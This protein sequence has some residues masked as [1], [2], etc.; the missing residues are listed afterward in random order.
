[1]DAECNDPRCPLN[2]RGVPHRPHDAIERDAVVD[3]CNDPQCPLTR[4]G[5]PHN[6][7]G[8]MDGPAA[9][10]GDPGGPEGR[11]ADPGGGPGRR[12]GG[13]GGSAAAAGGGAAAGDAGGGAGGPGG[14]DAAAGASGSDA[15]SEAGGPHATGS[16]TS[17]KGI[18]DE[19]ARHLRE[20]GA[21]TGSGPA[22]AHN[23]PSCAP[24]DAERIL[25]ASEPHDI[26]GVPPG[27]ALSHVRSR[28]KWLVKRHDAARGIIH[29]S[30][31]ERER[32]SMIMA[33]I[34][35]A[36]EAIKSARGASG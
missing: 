7:H 34:N 10:L 1:M 16:A 12:P 27:A 28:Y 24:E 31:P 2:R 26:L 6:S 36:F 8:P 29:K 23:G 3:P 17:S 5:M 30:A 11:G 22:A 9:G 18:L 25:R 4:L 13:P 32:S 15:A 20:R 14:S 35:D 33:K 19:A 21:G